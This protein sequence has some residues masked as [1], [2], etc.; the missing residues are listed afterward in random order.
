MAAA[1]GINVALFHY[2]QMGLVSLTTVAAF[3]SVG[4]ILSVAM[5]IVPGAT[6]YLLTEN[7]KRMLALSVSFGVAS[8]VGGYA[9]AY[10]IDCSIAGAM[11]SVS[12][13]LFLLA[14]L[15]SP[16]QGVITKRWLSA[17]WAG[18]TKCG[19]MKAEQLS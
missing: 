4:A 18:G 7:L 1:V 19:T 8:S 10:L 15:F 14:L 6:A 5:L 9:V 3:E 11:A 17:V 13:V 16:S 2:L 12:G